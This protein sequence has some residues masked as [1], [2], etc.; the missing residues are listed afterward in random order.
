MS[1]VNPN[2]RTW[3]EPRKIPIANDYCI[4][5]HDISWHGIT[6]NELT[7]EYRMDRCFTDKCACWR[8]QFKEKK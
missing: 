5:G 2:Y 8:F 3:P 6:I 7:A 4:C 1:F